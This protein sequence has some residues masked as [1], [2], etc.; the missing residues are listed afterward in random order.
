[1]VIRRTS[2]TVYHTQY[3]LGWA[4]KYR[5]DVLRGDVQYCVKELVAD[6]TTQY[7][8]M[9]DAMEVRP[10]MVILFELSAIK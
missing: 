5:R 3:H 2:H 7:D 1:M 9:I 6:I 10:D 4:P 8:I